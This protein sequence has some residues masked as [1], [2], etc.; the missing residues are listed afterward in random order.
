[1]NGFSDETAPE[2]WG[3]AVGVVVAGGAVLL[4][5]LCYFFLLLR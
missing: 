2:A 5:V 4:F 3:C 1:M